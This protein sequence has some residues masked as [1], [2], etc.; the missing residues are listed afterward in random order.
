MIVCVVA[1]HIAVDHHSLGGSL[2]TDQEDTE[3][4]FSNQVN[5][6][7]TSDIVYHRYQDRAVFWRTVDGILI[8]C[9]LGIPVGPLT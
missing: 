2:F 6:I 9:H 7:G 8:F 4:L 1:G 5:Q 3:V